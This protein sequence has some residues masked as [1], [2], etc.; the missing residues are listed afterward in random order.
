MLS[1]NE[2]LMVYIVVAVISFGIAFMMLK[3][4]S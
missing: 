1:N 4:N 3:K 2:I